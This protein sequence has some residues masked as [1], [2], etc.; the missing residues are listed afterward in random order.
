MDRGKPQQ[1]TILLY[2][3]P[4]KEI[5]KITT[6]FLSFYTEREKA[7]KKEEIQR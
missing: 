5:G 7:K 6:F 3:Y 4:T 2:R 1:L